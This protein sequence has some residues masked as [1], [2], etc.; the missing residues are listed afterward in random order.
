MVVIGNAGGVRTDRGGYCSIRRV[1]DETATAENLHVL[2]IRYAVGIAERHRERLLRTGLYRCG[3]RLNHA[4]YRSRRSD[5][6]VN[7][8]VISNEVQYAIPRDFRQIPV[9]GAS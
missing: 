9:P 7:S 3:G 8:A 2:Y 6:E 1:D 5:T 4:C